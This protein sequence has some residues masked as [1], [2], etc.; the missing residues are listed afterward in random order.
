MYMFLFERRSQTVSFGIHAFLQ[1]D[2]TYT[3]L[4][5]YRSIAQLKNVH[6]T[7][8]TDS[9]LLCQH[10]VFTTFHKRTVHSFVNQ[11]FYNLHGEQTARNLLLL[12]DLGDCIKPLS[13]LADVKIKL[14][15]TSLPYIT[16]HGRANATVAKYKTGWFAGCN[17]AR[18]NARWRLAP[19]ILSTCH[20]FFLKRNK[21]CINTAFYSIKH[22]VGPESHTDTPPPPPTLVK[23][24]LEGCLR[25]C[26]GRKTR[27]DAMPMEVI[28]ELLYTFST[29]QF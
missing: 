1:E 10:K 29:K 28:R 9:T 22:M 25:L 17:G 19:H 3:S 13:Q 6:N 18:Q 24:T 7:S 11:S 16:Q 21:G 20:F 8:Q 27:K 23:L 15:A 12:A 4:F 14:L 5:R 26:G 2:K